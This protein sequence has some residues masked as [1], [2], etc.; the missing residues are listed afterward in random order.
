MVSVDTLIL[1]STSLDV[2]TIKSVGVNQGL[3]AHS[4]MTISNLFNKD[5]DIIYDH[6]IVGV[7][8]SADPY[9]QGPR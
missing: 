8:R 9:I 7:G 5:I 4:F 2:N 1:A 6:V 3:D